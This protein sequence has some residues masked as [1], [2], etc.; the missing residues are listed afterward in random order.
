MMICLAITNCMFCGIYTQ[1]GLLICLNAIYCGFCCQKICW[2]CM[3]KTDS[4]WVVMMINK[5]RQNQG[6]ANNLSIGIQLMNIDDRT[7]YKCLNCQYIDIFYCKREGF[8]Y[9][10]TNLVWLYASAI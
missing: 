10:A 4:K 2:P 3:N 8:E 9:F 5:Y 6:T 1:R 7:S